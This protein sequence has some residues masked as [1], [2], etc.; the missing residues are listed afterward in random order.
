MN[1]LF[2]TEK[3]HGHRTDISIC[4]YFFFYLECVTDFAAVSTEVARVSSVLAGT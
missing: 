4:V 2:G 3:E 1:A